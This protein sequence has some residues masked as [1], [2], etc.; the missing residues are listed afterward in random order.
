[1]PIYLQSIQKSLSLGDLDALPHVVYGGPSG[2]G[3]QFRNYVGGEIGE[4][5]GYE[6]TGHG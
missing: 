3:P 1:M 2:R 5:W 6:T 4:M